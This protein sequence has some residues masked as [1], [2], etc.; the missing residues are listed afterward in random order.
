M[1]KFLLEN[2][3][4]INT[5]SG[6]GTFITSILAIY[7][8]REV[9]KQRLSTYKP[10]ILI[11]SF[12]VYINKSPLELQPN[13]SLYYKTDNFNEYKKNIDDNESGEFGV[14]CLYKVENLGFGPAKNIKL[15]WMYDSTKAL[16]LI[17][18]MLPERYDFN[19]HKPMKYYFLIDK[20]NEQFH[21]S[22][23]NE[24]ITKQNIDYLAPINIKEHSNYHSIP[25]EIIQTFYLFF[26]FKHNLITTKNRNCYSDE[27]F[28][29]LP[30]PHL[31]IEYEDLNGKKYSKN[32]QFKISFVST[33]IDEFLEMDKEFGY[34][35][36]SLN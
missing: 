36:F 3:D 35:L 33:Q 4:L 11:K 22:I 21:F 17:T 32:F 2:K 6:I 20:S 29:K 27:D 8:L 10:E 25:R 15:T 30:K 9:I 7:T 13:E 24:T 12:I 5:L 34:L 28:E 16:D 23:I 1:E 31:K 26:I 14:S 18:R 19:I